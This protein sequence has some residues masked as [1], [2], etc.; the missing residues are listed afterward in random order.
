MKVL[1]QAIVSPAPY[2]VVIVATANNYNQT[3]NDKFS[4]SVKVLPRPNL[5]PPIFT[6]ALKLVSVKLGEEAFFK[7]PAVSD[8]EGDK[9]TM[10][11]DA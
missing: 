5:T 11:I 6:A 7:L 9:F 3:K 2:P 8:K 10:V 4:I 1:Q